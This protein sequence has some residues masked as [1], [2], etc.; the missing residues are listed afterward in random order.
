M[1]GHVDKAQFGAIGQCRVGETEIDRQPAALFLRQPVGVDPG[2]G[3][4]QRR[5]A[6][7][8]MPSRREDHAGRRSF[9]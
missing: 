4:H 6:V 5:L 1:P 2:Q 3:T 7:V 8:D 9:I